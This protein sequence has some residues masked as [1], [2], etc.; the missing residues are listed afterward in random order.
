MYAK[1][2]GFPVRPS[3]SLATV[4]ANDRSAGKVSV[5][6]AQQYENTTNTERAG[7]IL[8][9]ARSVH[10]VWKVT[11]D[12]APSKPFTR[13]ASQSAAAFALMAAAESTP[14]Y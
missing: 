12:F 1:T 10:D 5:W 7:E 11:V 3:T 9:T 6:L 14:T 13:A 2:R 8:S 4:C